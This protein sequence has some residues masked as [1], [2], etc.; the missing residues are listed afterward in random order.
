M[1]NNSNKSTESILGSIQ[2]SPVIALGKNLEAF[3]CYISD[4]EAIAI[5]PY[6]AGSTGIIEFQKASNPSSSNLKKEVEQLETT[7]QPAVAYLVL[8]STD[9][10]SLVGLYAYLGNLR[11]KGVFVIALVCME[12]SQGTTKTSKDIMEQQKI[13]GYADSVLLISDTNNPSDKRS[14]L[15]ET[16][17]QIVEN[18]NNIILNKN[19]QEVNVDFEDIKMILDGAIGVAG[20]ATAKGAN[21]ASQVVEDLF[22]NPL[23]IGDDIK[24]AK[25]VLI[26]I[27]SGP[28]VELEMNEL[29]FITDHIQDNISNEA[30]VI[31][32]HGID[33]S[34]DGKLKVILLI[35]GI[36]AS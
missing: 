21:R 14:D 10:E 15:Y 8:S 23:M 2:P 25:K 24:S 13:C 34:L 19:N 9:T 35:S 3:L 22:T 26:S 30:E 7:G 18:L 12:G 36:T 27:Q 20:V 29:T 32:G 1:E 11:S 17:F 5:K 31:F 16:I 28:E 4:T 33:D 6:Y